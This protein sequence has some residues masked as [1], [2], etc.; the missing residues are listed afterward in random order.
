M[1]LKGSSSKNTDTL[2]SLM[3]QMI[4]MR[5]SQEDD[6]ENKKEMIE[7][8]RRVQEDV[9]E[10]RREILSLRPLPQTKL[11]IIQISEPTIRILYESGSGKPRRG[12]FNGCQV[13]FQ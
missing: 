3:C 13:S 9:S 11:D 4:E 10:S 12:T 2:R 1:T 8:L 6:S 7:R 5:D